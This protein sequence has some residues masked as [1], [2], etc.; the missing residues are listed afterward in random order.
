MASACFAFALFENDYILACV[1]LLGCNKVDTLVKTLGVVVA[2][3]L[4]D[5]TLGFKVSYGVPVLNVDSLVF[6][7][8]L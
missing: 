7:R 4:F 8:V 5:V 3:K 6:L 2:N 1:A